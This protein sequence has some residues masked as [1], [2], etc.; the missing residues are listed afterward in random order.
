MLS[1]SEQVIAD[2]KSATVGFDLVFS[3]DLDKAEELFKASDSAF[4]LLGSGACA[5]LQAAVSLEVRTTT[6]FHTRRIP[7]SLPLFLFQVGLIA[8]ASDLLGQ[9]EAGVRKHLKNSKAH[10]QTGRFPASTEW[11]LI[12]ADCVILL[13]LS[14]ALRYARRVLFLASA[15]TIITAS[16]TWA[17]SSVCESV[18]H[19]VRA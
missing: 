7:L 11:E 10:K 1:Q 5:F 14:Q 2:L 3:N 12:Y 9:A 13:G 4:H 19:F 17:I 6:F 15:K 8:E 18:S 16:H